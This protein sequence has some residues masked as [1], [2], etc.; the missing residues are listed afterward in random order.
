M[1]VTESLIRKNR[2]DRIKKNRSYEDD[3]PTQAYR[4]R[5]LERWSINQQ[6]SVF[7]SSLEEGLNQTESIF[8][9][10]AVFRTKEGKI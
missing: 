1:R 2:L 10:Q 8:D 4:E 9:K 6:Q 3:E 5:N 7:A